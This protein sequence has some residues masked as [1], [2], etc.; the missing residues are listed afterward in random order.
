MIL[1][2]AL[3]KCA[4]CDC[5]HRGCWGAFASKKVLSIGF[6]SML[7]LTVGA[8]CDCVHRGSWGASAS[9]SMFFQWFH[10]FRIYL[11][12]NQHCKSD[13]KSYNSYYRKCILNSKQRASDSNNY[14][15]GDHLL[16]V[17]QLPCTP[18]ASEQRVNYGPRD[19]SL[20]NHWL[21]VCSPRYICC[22]ASYAKCY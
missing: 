1:Q 4:A 13:C 11:L 8:A 2:A 5:V 20:F 15:R 3:T 21:A 19:Y 6:T 22:R 14:V 12:Q 7:A 17:V 10:V 16:H 18:T 9:K